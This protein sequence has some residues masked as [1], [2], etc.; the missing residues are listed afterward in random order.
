MRENKL[1]KIF[2]VMMI[3]A[4]MIAG[5][6][7]EPMDAKAYIMVTTDQ[8]EASVKANNEDG[9]FING[10][11][12]I[13]PDKDQYYRIATYKQYGKGRKKSLKISKYTVTVKKGKKVTVK[14]SA[15]KKYK[16]KTSKI[17]VSTDKTRT[18]GKEN[19]KI[20]QRAKATYSAKKGTVTIQGKKK[21]YCDVT[22]RAGNKFNIIRVTIK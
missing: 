18:N 15:L 6:I 8:I 9:L 12:R 5:L 22:V 19:S 11:T 1:K 7:N 20:I 2:M 14:C 10:V 4:F 21:G 17:T 3:F 13:V 16:N